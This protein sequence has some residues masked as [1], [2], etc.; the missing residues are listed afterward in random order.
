M[1]LAYSHFQV[2]DSEV[3]L[4]DRKQKHVSFDSS[5]ILRSQTVFIIIII[6]IFIIIN[7]SFF[8]NIITFINKIIIINI[9]IIMTISKKR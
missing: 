8:I 9:L 5:S 4:D 6:N 7:I 2:N 1:I 3:S